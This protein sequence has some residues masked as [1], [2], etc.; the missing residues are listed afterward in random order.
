MALPLVNLL[1]LTAT[2]IVL[3]A[4]AFVACRPRLLEDTLAPHGQ[5]AR[6]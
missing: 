5:G 2:V 3:L 4:G 1:F 6:T